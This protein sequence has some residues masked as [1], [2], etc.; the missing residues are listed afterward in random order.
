MTVF[1]A[2]RLLCILAHIWS[3]HIVMYAMQYSAKGEILGRCPIKI[4]NVPSKNAQVGL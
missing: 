3:A 4:E 1:T 2:K